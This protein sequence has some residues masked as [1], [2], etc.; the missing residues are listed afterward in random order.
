QGNQEQDPN[1]GNQN[2]KNGTKP[3][4][5]SKQ[6][7]SQEDAKKLLNSLKNSE[8][9]TRKRIGNGQ[10]GNPFRKSNSKDW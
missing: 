9:D 7:M 10:S 3:Q 6:Q 4:D 2:N 1:N 8:Q 5:P